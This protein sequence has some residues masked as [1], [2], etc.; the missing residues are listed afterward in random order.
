M[1]VTGEDMI[2]IVLADDH[3]VVRSSLRLLL[4]AEPDFEVVAEASNV[5]AALRSVA[6]SKPTILV[7]DL[8][9]PGARSSLEAIPS[10][11]EV[12]SGT[13][14]VVLTVHEDPE[15]AHHA[16]RAG[17]L[18]YVLKDAAHGEL[19]EAVRRVAAG[20]P[21]VNPRLSARADDRRQH[22]PAEP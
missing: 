14:V 9:M 6:G 17:A 21:Y 18:G 8:N 13:G 22:G 5:D 4:D 1:P 16:L 10:V 7:L 2:T 11:A 19:V 12:S 20:D 3:A 15:F